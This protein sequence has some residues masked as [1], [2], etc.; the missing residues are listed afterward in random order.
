[1]ISGTSLFDDLPDEE[2]L[3]PRH[4][5]HDDPHFD[6]TAMIDLVFMMNIFFLVTSIAAGLAEIELPA[7]R[8]CLTADGAA[9]IFIT[10]LDRADSPAGAV[11]LGDGTV[12]DPLLDPESQE[13]AVRKAVETAS[14]SKKHTVIIKAARGVPL[15]NVV[16]VAGAAVAVE[17]TELKLAVVEKE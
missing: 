4:S 1:M 7:A 3:L 16:R 9:S 12:G 15:R 17:G 8:H 11:Y 6:L 2:P 14:Q 5:M 10:I 13:R